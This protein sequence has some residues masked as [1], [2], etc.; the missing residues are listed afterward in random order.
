VVEYSFAV[1]DEEEQRKGGEVHD[2]DAGIRPDAASNR[3]VAFGSAIAR[4]TI[5]PGASRVFIMDLTQPR[6][7]DRAYNRSGRRG[8]WTFLGLVAEQVK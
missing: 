6:G 8:R 4:S 3:L 1:A 2:H 5:L 7:R